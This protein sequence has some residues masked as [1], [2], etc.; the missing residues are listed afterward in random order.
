MDVLKELG[1]RKTLEESWQYFVQYNGEASTSEGWKLS[2]QGKTLNDSMYLYNNLINFLMVTK[3]HYKF[4][5][6]RLINYD[7]TDEKKRQQANK[8]LTIYIPN[9]VDP[10]SFAEL[11]YLHIEDY[12]GGNDVVTPDTYTHYKNAIYYRN[13]RN[14]NGE[15]ISAN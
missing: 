8:L 7:F 14:E 6:K 11:V 3:C 9:G 15:Y 4:G 1:F 12:T 10:K 5:T 13:D 2:I